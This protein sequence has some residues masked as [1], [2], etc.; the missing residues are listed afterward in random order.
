MNSGDISPRSR[1]DLLFRRQTYFFRDTK[2][3]CS[4]MR[5][6]EYFCSEI[7]VTQLYYS[8]KINYQLVLHNHGFPVTANNHIVPNTMSL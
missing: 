8:V 2:D 5:I 4:H 6:S 7:L 3:L 1:L